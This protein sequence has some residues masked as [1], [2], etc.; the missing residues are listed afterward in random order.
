M[1]RSLES[2]AILVI[3]LVG[4]LAAVRISTNDP[5]ADHTI[6]RQPAATPK[7]DVPNKSSSSAVEMPP[8]QGDCFAYQP[9]DAAPQ[10]DSACGLDRQT[11]AVYRP[12]KPLLSPAEFA[13]RVI[14]SEPL[15]IFVLPEPAPLEAA[16][17][18]Y[19]QAYD[20]A[21]YGELVAVKELKVESETTAALIQP[22]AIVPWLIDQSQAWSELA[23]DSVQHYQRSY[24]PTYRAMQSHWSQHV[25]PRL[26]HFPREAKSAR[27]ALLLRQQADLNG[28][29]A[30]NWNDYQVFA[31]RELAS[32]IE[33][34]PQHVAREQDEDELWRAR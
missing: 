28:K 21:V 7:T 19:D 29:P 5:A 10:Y 12:L 23:V 32:R 22:T 16:R 27:K 34:K 15:P 14:R 17:T 24:V 20:T 31:E 6:A 9:A 1:N 13:A 11:G 25:A 2:L 26:R 4:T 30:L 8:S 18:G 3:C 33:P